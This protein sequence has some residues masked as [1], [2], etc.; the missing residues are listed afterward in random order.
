M[1][2]VGLFVILF[3]GFTTVQDLWDIF[4][5]LSLS[6]VSNTNQLLLFELLA[7]SFLVLIRP[8]DKSFS[9]HFGMP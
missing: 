4:G 6:L 3:A 5:D 7:Y 9:H 8:R 1:K 2:W